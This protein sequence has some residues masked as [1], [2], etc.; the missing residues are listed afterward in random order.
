[1]RYVKARWLHEQ[2]EIDFR[3]YVTDALRA[4]GNFDGVP[5]YYDVAY[6][7]SA[8]EE[9]RKPEEVIDNIKNGLR[10]LRDA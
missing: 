1:L 9:T 5:R 2:K 3:V 10:K 7:G 4:F 8:V 6:G